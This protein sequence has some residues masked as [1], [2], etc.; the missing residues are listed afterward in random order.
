MRSSRTVGER[1]KRVGFLLP[2]LPK[3]AYG[4][5]AALGADELPPVIVSSGNGSLVFENTGMFSEPQLFTY[6][7]EGTAQ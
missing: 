2:T 7:T 4:T 6:D 5:V 3:L 1:N